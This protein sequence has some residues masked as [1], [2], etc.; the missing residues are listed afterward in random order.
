MTEPTDVPRPHSLGQRLAFAT[1]A[2]TMMCQRLLQPYGLTLVQWI[3]LSALWRRD[4]LLVTQ[5]AEYSGNAAPATSRAVDRMVEKGLVVRERDEVDRRA[6]RVYLTPEGQAHDHLAL[7]HETVNGAL[8]HG[9]TA[10]E[11]VALFAMLD[12]VEANARSVAVPVP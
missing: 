6:V 11:A 10:S 1:A 7:F 2:S 4:G 9:F 8:L 12:R 3:I 5:L